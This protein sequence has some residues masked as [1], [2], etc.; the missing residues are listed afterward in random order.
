MTAPARLGPLALLLAACA[1][2][3]GSP[4]AGSPDAGSFDAGPGASDGGSSA[5]VGRACANT[6]DCGSGYECD[7]EVPGGYCLPGAPGGPTACR[8]PELPCPAGTVCSPVPWHQIS[9]VCMQ[10]CD[11]A[12][13]CR[14][15]LVCGVV[16]L[17]PGDSTSPTSGRKV[18]WP[19]CS[20]GMDQTCNDSALISSIHG[21]CLADGSCQ[22]S[23]SFQKNPD[24]GRCL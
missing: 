14:A 21:T 17:F 22:C 15:P 24:T 12:S 4:D 10:P 11:A 9:G 20:P 16:F 1:A 7:T 18:C 3:G 23:G 13:D 8:E 5:T 6:G 2:G 19:A